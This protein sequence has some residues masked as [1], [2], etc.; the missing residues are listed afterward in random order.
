MCGSG[1]QMG[2]QDGV[3]TL[4]NEEPAHGVRGALKDLK[5][6][7]KSGEEEVMWLLARRYSIRIVR[8]GVTCRV[9]PFAKWRRAGVNTPLHHFFPHRIGSTG[10]FLEAEGS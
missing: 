8:I 9:S 3:L 2:E 1:E 4:E 5:M 7:N 10:F 6:R